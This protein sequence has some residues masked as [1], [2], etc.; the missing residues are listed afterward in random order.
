MTADRNRLLEVCRLLNE[1]GARYL[2]VGGHACALHGLVRT[3]KDVDVL[4]PVD[5][6]NAVRVHDALVRLPY[7]IAKEHDPGEF[8]AKPIT[9]I[10]DD[11]RVDLLLAAGKTTFARAWTT[12]VE[13]E[14]G[15]V[16][17]PFVGLD[18]LLESK[19]TDRL[20]DR[21]DLVELKY[22]QERQ[23]RPPKA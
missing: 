9:I 3:T 6:E 13:R 21:A 11:P 17:V 15:G 4:I 5:R 2:I 20:R 16:R 7:G 23:E 18:A 19:D 22:L 1:S 10:G 8:I 14:I 12:H